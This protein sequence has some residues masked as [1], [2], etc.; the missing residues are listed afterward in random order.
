MAEE[1]GNPVSPE[2]NGSSEVKAQ[3]AADRKAKIQQATKGTRRFPLPA[4]IVLAVAV[5]ALGVIIVLGVIKANGNTEA[6]S[7][8]QS[9]ASI[10]PASAAAYAKPA[11][12]T[13]Y[14]GFNV[15]DGKAK[16]SVVVYID[17]QCPACKDFESAYGAKLQN[18]A[19]SG[20]INLEY[21]PISFLDSGANGKYSSRA[22][23]ALACVVNQSSDKGVQFLNKLYA[24]QP[25]ESENKV[26]DATLNEWAKSVGA[27]DISACIKDGTYNEFVSAATDKSTA[28]G[29]EGTPTVLVNGKVVTEN[30]A[31]DVLL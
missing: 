27:D 4:I 21:R 24:N 5:I 2:T 11:N 19:K 1:N 18:A 9:T 26:T 31:L 23:N 7:D 15:G 17:P 28:D 12:I 10:A 20:K 6:L 14:L 30:A 25:A 16:D 22:A 13:D 8:P 29:L 3:K